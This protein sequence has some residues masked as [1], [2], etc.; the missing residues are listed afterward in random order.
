MQ[1][2][3]V[4]LFRYPSLALVGALLALCGYAQLATAR[5]ERAP[6]VVIMRATPA[7]AEVAA[8]AAPVVLAPQPTAAPQIIYVDR[9][10]AAPPAE[11]AAPATYAPQG[12]PQPQPDALN[13]PAQNGGSVAAPGCPFPVVNGVCGNGASAAEA[14]EGAAEEGTHAGRALPGKPQIIPGG[15]VILP[16]ARP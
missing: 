2:V 6:V 12:A 11:S 16:T 7:L 5:A 13:D 14:D 4:G 10:V 9:V 3:A 15:I 8:P 1:K